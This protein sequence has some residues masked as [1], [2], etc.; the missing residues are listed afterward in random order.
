MDYAFKTFETENWAGYKAWLVLRKHLKFSDV[1][2][3]TDS[4]AMN[5]SLV[6]QPLDDVVEQGWKE[7]IGGSINA[8]R[9]VFEAFPNGKNAKKT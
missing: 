9:K 4:P 7:C 1:L 2:N 3:S 8:P 5:L 6:V